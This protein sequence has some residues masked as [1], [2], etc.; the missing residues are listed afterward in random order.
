MVQLCPWT[1]LYLSVEPLQKYSLKVDLSKL[2]LPNHRYSFLTL[3][4]ISI[5]VWVLEIRDFFWYMQGLAQLF[6]PA[7][8][9]STFRV[10]F[11]FSLLSFLGC[12]LIIHT[13]LHFLCSSVLSNGW[14]LTLLYEIWSTS[15][16]HCPQIQT[17]VP[18]SESV[19]VFSIYGSVYVFLVLHCTET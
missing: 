14:I 18:P 3:I 2:W 5:Y 17:S 4:L 1:Q 10:V 15:P 6:K 9:L 7:W 11:E 13:L 16:L 19:Q 12:L 8:F